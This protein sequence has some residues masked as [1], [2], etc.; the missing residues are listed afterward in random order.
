MIIK[1]LINK[2]KK[3][4]KVE[5]ECLSLSRSFFLIKPEKYGIKTIEIAPNATKLKIISGSLNAA[6]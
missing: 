6:E 5:H 2:K 4:R 1:K 3:F